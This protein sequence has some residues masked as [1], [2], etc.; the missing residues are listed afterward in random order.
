MPTFTYQAF[1]ES[2]S[3]VN[4]S[5]EA[6][7]VEEARSMIAARG[8]IPS[9]VIRGGGGEDSFMARLDAKL[10]KV[11]MQDLILFTKQFRTL[12]N[13]GLSIVNLLEVL[14]QQTENKKLQKTV[15]EISADIKSGQS[16]YNAFK[17]HEAIFTTLYCSMIRA[18]E[19]S[20]TL[21]EVLDRLIY[22]IE[23]EYKV[24][25]QIKSALI[26]PIVVL[27]ALVGAFIFL[28]TFVMPKFADTFGAAGIELPLPTKVC[29]A[30]YE[31]LFAYG[32]HLV[33]GIVVFIAAI[34]IYIRTPQGKLV[35][36]RLLL[37]MPLVGPVF[38]KGAMSRFASIFALL[39]SSGVS[40]L[41]TVTIL[42]KTIG[43]KAISME[44]DNL[45]E[46]LQEGR[47]ISGPLRA[48]QHFT[49]MIIN[50]ISIGEETGDL[51]SMLSE[52]AKH[53]DFE[54]EYSVQ[55]MSELMGPV[56]MGFLATIV[57][58][59]AMAIFFPIFDLTK[60]VQ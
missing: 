28:L 58:F 6:D 5:V 57:G 10:A 39:Q 55:R 19:V 23:H 32:I 21:P 3:S 7:T 40:I 37:R 17:K 25:K 4:G 49:P 26:Y 54:V 8:L 44:F 59:F 60:T 33:I 56:L 52:V 43:N 24:K 53:Y 51:D 50:M 20:G 45:K 31:F 41:E 27:V 1:T 2:G 30:M 22:I 42:A 29:I 48:S 15:A 16:M 12:F 36:D 13:A 34:I 11:K 9:K 14:E 18:G 35:K 46:K 38:Q 47:G